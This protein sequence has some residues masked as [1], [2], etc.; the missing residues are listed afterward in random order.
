MKASKR[1]ILLA[2]FVV[3]SLAA[4]A[5]RFDWVKSYSGQEPPGKFWNYIVSSV[6]DSHDNTDKVTYLK[7]VKK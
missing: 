7:L 2:V 6:T 3:L 5:Q 4:H 1:I